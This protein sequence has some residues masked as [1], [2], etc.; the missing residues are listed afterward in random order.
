[1]KHTNDSTCRTFDYSR[2]DFQLWCIRNKYYF[3][4]A[5]RSSLLQSRLSPPIGDVHGPMTHSRV[6]AASKYVHVN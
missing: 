6:T 2:Q 1:M 4:A 3:V 5:V